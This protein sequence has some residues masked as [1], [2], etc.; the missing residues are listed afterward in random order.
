[1]P[2]RDKIFSL[3]L[4][5]AALVS[6]H[7]GSAAAE[8]G[9]LLVPQPDPAPAIRPYLTSP[10]RA[11]VAIAALRARIKYVFILYQENRSFDAYFGGF[12]GARGL[13]SA[14]AAMTPG[15][16]Q[17]II[18]PDGGMTTIHPF[19]LG[20][21]DFAAD[22]D[23]MDHSHPILVEKM[24]IS[25]GSAAMDRFALAE[26]MKYVKPGEKPSRQAFQHGALPMAHI[27]CD[28]IPLLWN[29]ASRFVLFDAFFQHTIA[30]SAPNAI[31]LIAGQSGETQWLKHPDQATLAASSAGGSYASRGEPMVAN[32]PP[33]W[34]SGADQTSGTPGNP[35]YKTA[36]QINQT[37]ASLPLTFAGKNLP[38]LVKS[39]RDPGGDLADI[40]GDIPAIAASG[41]APLA[42]GWYQEGYDH[43]P[44]DPADAPA[45]GSHLSYVWHHNAAQYFGYVANNPEMAAHL[46]GLGDFFADLAA[47]RLPQAGGVFY[48][49]GGFRNIA[50]LLPA[51]PDPAVRKKFQGDDDH[52]GYSD[53]EISEALLGREVNAI[54]ESPYW[55]ESAIIITFDEGGGAYDHVPPRLLETGPDGKALAR[56]PRIPLI[57]ISPY[58]RAHVVSHEEG[59]HNEVIKFLDHL[60]RLPPLATLPEEAAARAAGRARLGQDGLGPKD[61]VVPNEGDLLSAF[62]PGRLAGTTP[63]LP[64][65]YAL[66]PPEIL[67]KLP[68]YGGHGCQAIGVVPVDLARGID[69]SP[70]VGFNPRP[71]TNPTGEE[72]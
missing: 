29:Y 7:A 22:L 12:P 48:I 39:D 52:P 54:A 67:A 4:A 37:Y 21:A 50:G 2:V 33:F 56:G 14:P 11:T 38:T 69:N 72:R 26:E 19:R 49:R 6:G 59:D 46:R 40:S 57:V 28:T 51:D 53:S 70:P 71:A 8:P 9:A 25:E 42:W 35:R 66:T 44:S 43:E 1:M 23:D 65:E 27:D 60:Y 55:A 63:P 18:K 58:A 32:P 62:D 64:P 47:K 10:T 36:S 17:P 45:G 31:A 61:A 20:P 30:P 16:F 3:S 13:Y 15:F 24:H 34:G 68:L 41:R 5:F